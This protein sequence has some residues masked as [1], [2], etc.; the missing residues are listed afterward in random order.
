MK[1]EVLARWGR[2]AEAGGLYEGAWSAERGIAACP[3][4]RAL[5]ESRLRYFIELWDLTTGKTLGDLEMPDVVTRLAFVP[6]GA[7]LVAATVGGRLLSWDVERRRRISEVQAHGSSI[8]ALAFDAAGGRLVSASH[9]GTARLW[10]RERGPGP[11]LR[12]H[13]SWVTAAALSPNGELAM[14][15]GLNEV[16]R[17]WRT[18]DGVCLKELPHRTMTVAFAPAGKLGYTAPAGDDEL[19]CWKL[20][21]VTL[22]WSRPMRMGL[23]H[24]AASPDGTRLAGIGLLRELVIFDAAD[25]RELAR[26]GDLGYAH[27]VEWERDGACLQVGASERQVFRVGLAG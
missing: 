4:D 3:G 12:G 8:K 26:L 21:S 14:T 24:L 7:R 13:Q 17:V 16:V 1:L 20:P 19:R 5:G 18:A 6:G 11:S 23:R 22:L 2:P 10:D 25:G 15:A 27:T 9:D